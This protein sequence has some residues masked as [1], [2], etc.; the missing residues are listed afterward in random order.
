MNKQELATRIWESA[1]AMRSKIEANEYKDYILGFIF[2]KFL[3]EK[4]EQFL[5]SSGMSRGEF[6]EL[7]VEKDHDTVRFVQDNIGYFIS[8]DNLY[9]TW[10]AR[11]KDFNVGDVRDALS[12]FARLV[13]PSDKALFNKIFETLQT[14]LSKLG[15]N[16]ASQTKAVRKLLELIKDI[17]M[18]G[19]QGYDVLGFIYEFLIEKFAANAGKKAG[20]F[21]TPHEVSLLISRIIASHLEGRSEIQIYDPTSGS[22][23]LLLNIGQ[24]VARHMG[25][26]D[27]IKYFAQELKANTYNLT[28]M[29]LVMRGIKPDNIVTRNADTLE[30][31][32]P[33]FN[34]EDPVG[35]Y[36]PLYVDAVVSNPPYSQ[37]W[38]SHGRDADPR[39]ARFGLA[40]DG[41]AD[42]AFLLHDLYHVKPEGL[43]TIV[44]PHGVLFRGGSEATIRQHLIEHNHI[45]TVIGLPANIFFGTGIPTIIMVLKQRRTNDDVLFI[46]ASQ[47][48]KKIGKNNQLRASDIRRIADAVENRTTI[49]RFARPVSRNEIRE[50]DYNLNLPRYVSATPATESVDLHATMFGGI[51]EA[52]IDE[53]SDFWE[54]MPGL[55]EALFVSEGNGYAQIDDGDLN[56]IIDEHPSVEAFRGVV[57]GVLAGLDAEL[58]V[59][60]VKDRATV[61]LLQTKDALTGEVL[62]RFAAAPLVESY[63]AY[64]LLHDR[65]QEVSND[66]EI[67]QSEGDSAIRQVDPV[68]VIKKKQKTKEVVEEQDGWEGRIIPFKL[69]QAHLLPQMMIETDELATSLSAIDNELR[70][71]FEG[72]SEEDLVDL[73]DVLNAAGDAFSKTELNKSVRALRKSDESYATDSIEVAQ[74]RAKSLLD[75]KTKLVKKHK[76]KA[77][78]LEAATHEVINNLSNVEADELLISKWVNPLI[79]DLQT[80]PETVLHRLKKRLKALRAKYSN[81][82]VDLDSSIQENEQRLSGL[83]GNLTGSATDIEGLE[84]LRGL[85]GGKRV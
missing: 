1:N 22:G 23:S 6:P 10:L 80:M 25:D 4:Q 82:L 69:A 17:P 27:R 19:R 64:Q 85:L 43:M 51:P 83:L 61:S 14:G 34:E 78:E 5:L 50:N 26:P 35:T 8:Y 13:S 9:S 67:I 16:A 62:T 18:D 76:A 77:A 55:R 73:S 56:A 79:A 58:N 49:E 41:K 45:D 46:D 57:S 47:G 74:I 70:A 65:W 81:N 84:A 52:E 33:M 36:Q 40:P 12:A 20:E 15:D 75:D 54:V 48:F 37:K 7:L 3:A 63:D 24:A 71:M 31:D 53:L 38:D 72:F 30:Q 59:R 66:L 39:F 42:Y 2:Y 21:Y 68:T 32:W 29:N 60:L 28:R 11:N 44:L